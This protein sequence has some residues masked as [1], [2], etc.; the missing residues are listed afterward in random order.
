MVMPESGVQVTSHSRL[1]IPKLLIPNPQSLVTSHQSLKNPIPERIAIKTPLLQSGVIAAG[2]KD[3]RGT[4]LVLSL[5]RALSNEMSPYKNAP[6]SIP[7]IGATCAVPPYII[8]K[9]TSVTWIDAFIYYVRRRSS[10]VISISGMF[11]LAPYAGSLCHGP[12]N[13]LS[14]SSLFRCL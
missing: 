6:I 13:A 5:K 11:R 7:E 2:A 12:R 8:L 14:R 1:L 3:F 4:T 9:L 10:Q